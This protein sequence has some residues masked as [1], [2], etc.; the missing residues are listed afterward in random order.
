MKAGEA[1]SAGP[2][3]RG[4]I[5]AATIALAIG[6]VGFWLFSRAGYDWRVVLDGTSPWTFF[7]LMATL[8]MAGFPIS[9]C[10]IYAGLAFDAPTAALACIGALAIN[11]TGSYLLMRTVFREPIMRLLA[12]RGWRI[13]ELKGYSIFRFV[14]IVRTVPGPP[15]FFQNLALS[16]AGVPFWSYLWISLLAQGGIALGVIYCSGVLSRD[17]SSAGGIVA[18][19]ILGILVVAK[20]VRWLVKR[21][22]AA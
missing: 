22:K 13:P 4:R 18:L 14:F 9:V 11:M 12:R 8:P 17:P 1:E 20:T 15:F 7:G 19:V 10:Y 5:A 21:R 3:I 16:V 2:A 6:G